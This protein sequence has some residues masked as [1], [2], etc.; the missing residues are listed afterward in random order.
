MAK[1][2]ES[3]S[4][5][6]TSRVNRHGVDNTGSVLTTNAIAALTVD[7]GIPSGWGYHAPG[8]ADRANAPL[9]GFVTIY[10]HH[11][12]GGL[13]YPMRCTLYAL[14]EAFGVLVVRL[15]PN[16]LRYL[17]SLCI[18]AHLHGGSFDVKA[19]RLIFCFSE[20]EDWIS[21]SP[22]TGFHFR[23]T[24][25]DSDPGEVAIPPPSGGDEEESCSL[26]ESSSDEDEIE[27]PLKRLREAESTSMRRSQRLAAGSAA[28][29]WAL[30]LEVTSI[31][32]PQEETDEPVSIP[33]AALAEYGV[34]EVGFH[35]GED[36]HAHSSVDPVMEATPGM[37]G[38]A[39]V[40]SDLEEACA[41]AQ[42]SKG[43][44]KPAVIF[45][46]PISEGGS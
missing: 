34:P 28:W 15:H 29:V 40:L 2:R 38:G 3:S 8:S 32:G 20:S 13:R 42:E 1:K 30:V 31:A 4:S 7:Y 17:V 46:E 16:A 26:L 12:R 25:P 24:N 18:F 19:A 36:S 14:V 39:L 44:L 27:A 37:A 43:S 45:A 10:K 41:P 5:S 21:M 11:L 22:K 9:D 33:A 35:S 6:R 23:W